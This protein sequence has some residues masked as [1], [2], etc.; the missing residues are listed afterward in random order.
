MFSVLVLEVFC[1]GPVR[2]VNRKIFLQ[3]ICVVVKIMSPFSGI[4]ASGYRRNTHV[5]SVHGSRPRSEHPSK[6]K[7]GAGRIS[8]I[9]FFKG[10]NSANYFLNKCCG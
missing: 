6:Q 10:S 8:G 7:S 2:N 9:A 5:I 3:K 1:E 4:K